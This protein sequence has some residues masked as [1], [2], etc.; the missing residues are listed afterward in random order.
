MQKTLLLIFFFIGFALYSQAQDRLISGRLKASD[1]SP[2]PGVS[3]TVKGTA[4]GTTTDANG[5]YELSAPIGA[6]LVFS[7]IGF[8]TREV[9]VT[10][11][12]SSAPQKTAAKAD[13]KTVSV[14]KEVTQTGN[15][16]RNSISPKPKTPPSS[17]VGVATLSD[18]SPVFATPNESEIR[19][20]PGTPNVSNA[21]TI[22]YVSGWRARL[23]YGAKARNG[24]YVADTRTQT[25]LPF[26]LSVNS[27]LVVQSINR[28]PALQTEFAQGRPQNGE[29]VWRDPETGE[30][31]SWGPK[32]RNLEYDGLATAY[33]SRGS[34]TARGNGNGQAAQS[35]SPYSFFR[36]GLSAEQSLALKTRIG[37]T[38]LKLGFTNQNQQKI[39]PG[40]NTSSHK[41]TFYGKRTF[42][43]RLTLETGLFYDYLN[44]QLPNRSGNWANLMASVLTTT[45]TFDNANGLS[46]RQATDNSASY[47]LSD[48]HYRTYGAD[49]SDNP[50]G[51]VAQLPDRQKNSNLL[52]HITLKYDWQ[53]VNLL[54]K[55]SLEKQR[56]YAI[57]GVPPGMAASQAGRLTERTYRQTNQQLAF[58]PSYANW[59][60]GSYDFY[61]NA[62]L[63]YVFTHR[64]EQL[65]RQDGWDMSSGFQFAQ[66]DSL[67]I[68]QANPFRQIHELNPSIQLR[69]RELVSFNASNLSYFSSTYPTGAG[70]LPA[71]GLA[72]HFSELHFLT[73]SSFLTY[74]KVFANYSRN[75]QEAPLI[76]NQWQYNS[77]PYASNNY[78][79]YQETQE[80]VSTQQ[81]KP[82]QTEK[83]ELGMTLTLWKGHLDLSASYFNN[84]TQN[85]LVPVWHEQTVRL[86]NRATLQNKGQEWE[87][88]YRQTFGAF[89]LSSSA[90]FQ[91]LRPVVKELYGSET[92]IPVAGFSDISSNL[93]AGQPYG[94]LVGTAWKRT[95]NG[96]LVIGSDGFPLVDAQPR[97]IGNPNPNW[98][99]S[100]D[101]NL[102]WRNWSLNV[103]FNFRHG[104]DMWNGTQATL[105]YLGMSQLTQ[106]QRDT[107][108]YLFEGVL[109]NGKPNGKPVDFANPA[110]GLEGNRWVRYGMTGVD[111][112][113]IQKSSWVRLNELKVSYSL[114]AHLRERLSLTE[115]K[116][117][118][119]GRNLWL[120]TPYTGV[121]PAAT[122]FGYPTASGLDL[123]NAPS[124]RSYGISLQ[125]TL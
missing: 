110:N 3:I 124:L 23:R 88:T 80:I 50:Y 18:D 57:F 70:W 43:N 13:R 123:F 64:R 125:L 15:A 105:N 55:G 38:Q 7:F 12:N 118:F 28:L 48:G 31:F 30:L 37:Q 5:Y 91:R 4:V 108:D 78:R 45:P 68:R 35:Y 59:L 101:Q 79:H 100:T 33:D 46:R 27:S 42:Q 1:G 71:A 34:L 11:K 65:F 86:E 119:T 115:A 116:I 20:L 117:S 14:Q 24:V 41:W 83:R 9:L 67:V 77:T 53:K 87:V 44:D 73:Y 66:A 10:E 97:I 62:Q 56:Q 112:E 58:I 99:A 104:G 32:I 26:Q 60:G 121:D 89:H 84:L 90:N 51:L 29:P 25:T 85:A 81:T 22:R 114:A 111:E 122:L 2:L 94:V 120:W 76:Y 72:F 93:I 52:T 96:Q 49:Q 102:Q 19:G 95:E 106:Q 40:A 75:L 82:E 39:I 107:R 63:S 16:S 113:S 36:N 74:G 98:I 21:Y 69:Y 8:T 61:L 47:L 54:L 92:R 6:T 17:K 103:V 109:E